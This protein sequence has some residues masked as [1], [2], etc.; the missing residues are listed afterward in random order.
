M[1]PDLERLL[2]SMRIGQF[3]YFVLYYQLALRTPGIFPALAISR[4]QI[5]HKPNLRYTLRGRPQKL[6]R[7]SLRELN[8]GV[9]FALAIFDLLATSDSG[10]GQKGFCVGGDT[11]EAD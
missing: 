10:K 2:G 1:P 4:K 8:L 6:Q 9:R 11:E 7:F 3:K 5:R